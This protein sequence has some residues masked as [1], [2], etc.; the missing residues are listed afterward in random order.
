MERLEVTQAHRD[1]F[2]RLYHEWD[3]DTRHLSSVTD[4]VRHPAYQAIIKMGP[5]AVVIMLEI[6]RSGRTPHFFHAL[7]VIT[8]AQPVSSSHAGKIRLMAD[9][10]V[11]W[12]LGE[13]L[14]T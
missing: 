10:W 11:R 3:H 1:R 5:P 14:V 7:S 4:M 2:Q 8:K 6:F 13:G 12:G 9:D